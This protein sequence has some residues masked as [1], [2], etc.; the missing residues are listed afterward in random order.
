MVVC[1][2][3]KFINS[4]DWI[5]WFYCLQRLEIVDACVDV[6][7]I[8]E[9]ETRRV[10]LPHLLADLLRLVDVRKWLLSSILIQTHTHD[11]C[12]YTLSSLPNGLMTTRGFQS[13]PTRTLCGLPSRYAHLSACFISF[14]HFVHACLF[15]FLCSWLY[16]I[17]SGWCVATETRKLR[18][19]LATSRWSYSHACAHARRHMS[20]HSPNKRSHI[21]HRHLSLLLESPLRYANRSSCQRL[22]PL[23]WLCLALKN[24]PLLNGP[25]VWSYRSS[26][27]SR[28]LLTP[29]CK[30]VAPK[31]NHTPFYKTFALIYADKLVRYSLIYA[32]LIVVNYALLFSFHYTVYFVSSTVY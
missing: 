1:Y 3:W 10:H 32:H 14:L 5:D 15:L 25:N 2:L 9:D 29:V 24:T 17:S 22:L 23:P 26:W 16:S 11:S 18:G 4:S 12:S 28:C 31:N 6:L 13:Y 8:H 20:P 7:N 30:T 27:S 21:K 19:P